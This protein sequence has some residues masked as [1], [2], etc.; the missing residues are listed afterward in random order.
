VTSSAAG[1]P[2]WSPSWDEPSAEPKLGRASAGAD[3]RGWRRP[4]AWPQNG[5][6]RSTCRLWR[7]LVPELNALSGP[8]GAFETVRAP[9]FEP[10]VQVRSD[11]APG[12]RGRYCGVGEGSRRVV[13]HDDTAPWCSARRPAA[14]VHGKLRRLAT[15]G[16][17]TL[18]ADSRGNPD[19]RG[20]RGDGRTNRVSVPRPGEQLPSA[21]LSASASS[22]DL[23]TLCGHGPERS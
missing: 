12:V 15:T 5:V 11:P 13:A 3:D 7:C 2:S 8:G 17:I 16:L 6:V 23:R 20:A 4:V 18:N 10:G 1:R 14:S 19:H 9:A 21:P 22:A